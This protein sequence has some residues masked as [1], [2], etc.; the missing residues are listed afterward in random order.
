MSSPDDDRLAELFDALVGLDE[1]ARARALDAAGLDPVRRAELEALLDADRSQDTRLDR[2]LSG[3]ALRVRE[4]DAPLPREGATIGA[5][6]IEHEL[7]AGGMGTV[8]LVHRADAGDAQRGALKLLRGFPTEEGRKRL[9]Q[10]R[11]VLATLEHPY[12]A[13]LIDGGETD[14]GQPYFVMEYVDGQTATAFAARQRLDAAARVALVDRIAE[15]VAHAHQRLVIHRDLKPSN[16]L[17]RADGTPR[18][19]DFGVAKLVDAAGDTGGTSTRVWTPGYASPEQQAGQAVTTATDVFALGV[20]LRELL[21]GQRPDGAA[22]DPA[23][24]PV[25]LDADLRGILAKASADDAAARYPTVEALRDDLARWRDGR[26][27]RAA[28]DTALYRARKFVRRHRGSVSLV[29]LVL[30]ALGAFVWRLG[31]ERNR[32]L[33]AEAAARTA[34][35]RSE[36]SEAETVRQLARA[37]QAIEF[38]ASVFKRGDPDGT[39]GKPVTVAGLLAAAEQQLQIA[40]PNDAGTNADFFAVLAQVYYKLGDAESG[41]RSI[42][43]ALRDQTPTDRAQALEIAL[44]HE[45]R[46]GF[47]SYLGRNADAAA[48]MDIATA[49]R[50]QWA[51]DDAPTRIAIAWGKAISAQLRGDPAAAEQ[52]ARQGLEIAESSNGYEPIL[53]INL[54]MIVGDAA[55]AAGRFA[56]ALSAGDRMLAAY[57]RFPDLQ[58]S[59]LASVWQYR[60]RALQGLGRLVEAEQALSMAIDW[61]KRL[62]EDRGVAAANLHNDRGILLATLGRF[63]DALAAYTRFSDLLRAAGGDPSV[64]TRLLNNRCDANNGL[65]DY[66]AA[67][68]DCTAAVTL[69]RAQFPQNAP[70]RLA[71]ESQFARTLGLAGRSG[72]SRRLFDTVI[73]ASVEAFGE[74]AVPVAI[75]RFR[76][77]RSALIAGDL[78]AAEALARRALTAFEAA[79]PAPH[80]WRGRAARMLGLVQLAAG[81]VDDAR[82]AL[83]VAQT[84]LAA[85]LPEGHVLLA[86]LRADQAAVLAASGD[87][88]GARELLRPVLG[89]LR[90]ELAAQEVDRARIEELA[91]TLGIN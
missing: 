27:V 64:D 10:E 21:S 3:A 80:P 47:L 17:V 48:E 43:R 42:D 49:L 81:R 50:E 11:R 14:D 18:V 82:D 40:P 73:A 44:R 89:S 61:Q 54:L 78:V 85:S 60:A 34:L 39:L 32:A 24:V 90:G 88:D 6:R 28:R 8:F 63:R 79:F 56:D 26:P 70:P 74:N 41:L 36:S 58:R 22:C 15:A 35:N 55:Q 25:A 12:I 91:H 67:L 76:A 29:V 4:L 9:R 37:R 33:E 77:S 86:Q 13:R 38:L 5:W 30:V 45:T 71:V 65:G 16:V 23:L 72:E 57:D 53:M 83:G 59:Q 7:G 87:R 62:A 66:P 52:L 68:I 1:P 69:I 19:L 2:A 31:V 46:M 75:A 20:L 84:E 51:P